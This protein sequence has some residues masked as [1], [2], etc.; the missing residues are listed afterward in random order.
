MYVGASLILSCYG[1]I[2]R[3]ACYLSSTT[4][5]PLTDKVNKMDK[6]IRVDCSA[7][8]PSIPEFS[9][10]QTSRPKQP[11]RTSMTPWNR[12]TPTALVLLEWKC[13]QVNVKK[14]KGMLTQN[15]LSLEAPGWVTSM[16]SVRFDSHLP[17]QRHMISGGGPVVSST[18]KCIVDPL[19][20]VGWRWGLHG[21]ELLWHV[22]WNRDLGNLE[23]WWTLELSLLMSHS[24]STDS[25]LWQG[26]LYC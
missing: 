25:M 13:V 24:S 22:N 4:F 12:Q 3:S 10:K 20:P 11:C 8:K 14:T 26:L 17:R 18:S 15:V 2:A 5:K 19:S 23:A 9:F 21:F 6:I 1:E 16:E 7:G